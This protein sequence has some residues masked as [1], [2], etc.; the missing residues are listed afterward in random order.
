MMSHLG[1][2]SPQSEFR[3]IRFELIPI[4]TNAVRTLNSQSA[5]HELDVWKHKKQSTVFTIFR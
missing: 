1:I 3:S 2:I 5:S 4:N